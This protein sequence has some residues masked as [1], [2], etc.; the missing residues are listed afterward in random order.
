ML[1]FET[2]PVELLQPNAKN[3]R[4][5]SDSQIEELRSSIREFGFLNPILVDD[6]YNII[7]GHGRLRAALLEGL[8][9]LPCIFIE[10]LTKLQIKA[11]IIA[12]NK[13]AL[14]AGW[15]DEWL[16]ADLLEL[17]ENDFDI[18]AIGFSNEEFND[19]MYEEPEP[20]EDDFNVEEELEKPAICQMGDIWQLGNHRVMC[21]DSTNIEAVEKL[22]DGK[23]ADLVVTDPPYNVDYEGSTGLKIENDNM[24]DGA[25][26]SF[27]NA[28]FSCMIQTTKDGGAIYCFHADS[29]GFNFRGAFRDAG[30]KT[31]QCLVWV[32]NALVMGRQDYQ[33]Q[34]EPILYGWKLGA[35]HYFVDERTNT[36][37]INENKPRKNKEHPTMKPI[38]LCSRLINN[39]SKPGWLVQDLFGGSGSVLIAAEQLNR[40]CYT[41]ELAEKY[42][43]VIIKRWEEYTGKKAVKLNV[44]AQ[45]SL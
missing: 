45:R 42:C 3:P 39:S 19:L 17:K 27:L 15:N 35:A 18:G 8:T 44:E 13:L 36:T 38:L 31:A 24:S 4:T 2:V 23:L 21:G 33:W 43:D 40:T 11:Y 30:W 1:K 12:D 29:E 16:K 34:H 22:M 14:N 7:A 37:V 5:H 20:E 32:K 6:K 9:E 28:A 41:M 10:G 25:F 26:R